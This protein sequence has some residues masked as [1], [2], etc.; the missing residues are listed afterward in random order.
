MKIS[1]LV[2]NGLAVGVTL[3]GRALKSAPKKTIALSLICIA[4]LN[5][6][7][8]DALGGKVKPV[9]KAEPVAAVAAPTGKAAND[10]DARRFQVCT[11]LDEFQGA[12]LPVVN[13]YHRDLNAIQ[14][15]IANKCT[16]H[17]AKFVEFADK[18]SA[19]QG[20]PS[21]T[22]LGTGKTLRDLI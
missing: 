7:V 2:L 5:S 15:A 18:A 20:V 16:W 21:S 17:A 14:D 8:S 3:Y 10:A 13:F 22:I 6:C 9:D 19:A 4:G 12:P 1:A 11:E